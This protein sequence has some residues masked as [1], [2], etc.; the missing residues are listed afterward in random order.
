M[1]MFEKRDV[2][3]KFSQEREQGFSLVS[4]SGSLRSKRS[5]E[6]ENHLHIQ[7]EPCLFRIKFSCQISGVCRLFVQAIEQDGIKTNGTTLRHGRECTARDTNR[8][9]KS[10]ER[11]SDFCHNSYD[12]HVVSMASQLR[13]C[14]SSLRRSVVRVVQVAQQSYLRIWARLRKT[15][16]PYAWPAA[17][18]Q[19]CV[20]TVAWYWWK[21]TPPPG[22]AVAGL[23]FVAVLM[24]VRGTRF[25]RGEEIGWILIAFLL[26]VTE[27]DAIARDR[28]EFASQQ[29]ERMTQENS[30]F[31]QIA[32]GVKT[33]LE[34]SQEQFA[35]TLERSNRQIG[36]EQS[37][38]RQLVTDINTLTGG[39]SY[40]FLT[41]VPGQGFL[42]FEHM[43]EYPLYGVDA[44]IVT[45]DEDGKI[46][47]GQNF[48]GTTISVGDM[49]SHHGNMVP[50]PGN[51]IANQDFFDANIFFTA[52]NGDWTEQM[53]VKKIGGKYVRA[54]YVK[55]RFTSL[56]KER[57]LCETIDPGFPKNN[58]GN[59]DSDFKIPSAKLPRCQ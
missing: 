25:T 29:R 44:R 8:A 54:V 37:A 10:V 6:F 58:D 47:E 35:I 52:R 3:A 14:L 23:A 43:G 48:M 28:N 34:D 19:V 55:G 11:A 17:V 2:F 12:P 21:A 22:Y 4:V 5:C 27:F 56:K 7:R 31:E 30:K 20:F 39:D 45:L 40:C 24:A 38:G 57:P 46:I 16:V 26:C 15:D 49:I 36:L 33:S 53:R 41:Y 32:S 9:I 13:V 42:F 50:I 51:L 1:W 59:I 18:L